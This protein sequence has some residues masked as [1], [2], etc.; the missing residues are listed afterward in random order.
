ML[1]FGESR[2]LTSLPCAWPQLIEVRDGG[3]ARRRRSLLTFAVGEQNMTA[4]AQERTEFVFEAAA[5]VESNIDTAEQTNAIIQTLIDDP[6]AAIGEWD[7][8]LML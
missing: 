2:P 4:D 8:P 1:C 6:V 7:E 5:L 3:A